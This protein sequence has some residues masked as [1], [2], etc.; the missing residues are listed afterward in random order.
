[1]YPLFWKIAQYKQELNMKVKKVT[2]LHRMLV[3]SMIESPL[4]LDA[5]L[6]SASEL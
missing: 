4:H 3:R 5:L 1:M 2:A 6:F